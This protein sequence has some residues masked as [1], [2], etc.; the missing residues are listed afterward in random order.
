VPVRGLNGTEFRLLAGQLLQNGHGLRFQ[1]GGNSMQPSILDGDILEVL[2]LDARPVRRGDV[3]LVEMD[4]GNV[5]AHRVI[6]TGGS[7]GR[8]G[9]LLKGDSCLQPD[10]WVS[11]AQVLGRAVTLERGE[12]KFDLT[13]PARRAIAWLW[14]FLSSLAPWVRWL[15]RPVRQQLKHLLFTV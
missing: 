10:G 15:P 14:V 12:R 11:V 6:K 13:S 9:F 8:P 1:A 5:I 7:K 2:P 3:L 4:G